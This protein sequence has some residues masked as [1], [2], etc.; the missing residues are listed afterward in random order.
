[1]DENLNQKIQDQGHRNAFNLFC[2]WTYVQICRPQ[3]IIPFLNSLRPSLIFLI[4]LCICCITKNP[5]VNKGSLYKE[6]QVKLYLLLFLTMVS[7]IVFSFYRRLSFNFVFLIYSQSIFF[8]FLFITLVNDIKKTERILFL[9]CCGIG[10]Y[11]TVYLFLGD[12][13]EN[14]VSFGDM[15]DS[16]DIAYVVISFVMFNFYFLVKRGSKIIS[17]ISM[18]NIIVGF[19]LIIYSGSRG[20][21]IGAAIASVLLIL[22]RKGILSSSLKTLLILSLIVFFSTTRYDFYRYKTIFDF[23][24]DYNYVEEEGRFEIWKIGINMMLSNPLTGVGVNCF[25]EAV[26]RDR[27]ARGAETYKWQ[28]AHNSAVQ[29]GTETGVIGFILFALLSFR[30]LRSFNKVRTVSND[31]RLRKLGELTFI[32]FIGSFVVMMFLSQAYSIIWV[33]YIALSVVLSRLLDMQMNS[34]GSA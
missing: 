28:T 25:P 17:I 32:G 26:G 14:R 30:A 4:L 20:G 16:N 7:S 18:I 21:F 22:S 1:M 13:T 23:K 15:F 3:D 6:I 29:I 24:N 19:L 9:V 8:F 2:V 12:T 27:I 34:S 5:F 33:F 10:I 31:E 11:S